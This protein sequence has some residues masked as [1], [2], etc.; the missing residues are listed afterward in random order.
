MSI[1]SLR[2][3]KFIVLLI[4][5]LLLALLLYYDKI[6]TSQLPERENHLNSYYN[7]HQPLDP[8][9]KLPSTYCQLSLF[10]SDGYF[11]EFDTDWERRKQIYHLQEKRNKVSNARFLFFQN[12]WEPNFQCEFE[13]R[14][15]NS[16]D[17]GK[18][19]CD[20]YR[21]QAKINSSKSAS[22]IY[23]FGSNGDFS[24]ETAI[25]NELNKCEI[26]TFDMN[27]YS[28]PP[29]ICTFHQAKLGDGKDNVSKTLPMIMQLLNHTGR[30][31]DILKVDI[32]GY[33]FTLFTDLFKQQNTT[34]PHI[35]QILF[36]IHLWGRAIDEESQAT[37][38][39]FELFRQN[40]YVIFHKESNLIDPQIACEYALLKLNKRF[41]NQSQF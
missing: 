38:R 36:E 20:I 17:G 30:E 24:F 28:C 10:E 12:N 40:H 1:A 5:S 13:R 4:L 25:K 37:H 9:L 19:V 8:R 29:N 26:H 35:R 6:Y 27:L 22:L 7:S 18:W 34:I 21:I 41:F 23:S 33:E 14:L 3:E 32:E 11:C 16:G 2:N 39:L 15:G 31:I